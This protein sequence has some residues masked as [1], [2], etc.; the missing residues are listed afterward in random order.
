MN[1]VPSLMDLQKYA[2]NRPGQQEVIRQPLYDTAVYAT[3]GSTGISFFATPI[4]QGASASPGN[5]GNVKTIADTNMTLAGQ[6]PAGQNFMVEQIEV[7]VTPGASAATTTTFT[8][9]HPVVF[10]VAASA[11]TVFAAASDVNAIYQTG[12]LTLTIGSKNYLQDGPLKKFAPQNY[13]DVESSVESTS[14][15]VGQTLV[16]TAR[17]L[18]K[19]YNIVPVTLVSTQNFNVTLNWPV[20]VATPSGFNA[21]VRCTLNGYLFRNSQ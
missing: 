8:L 15:T 18:G 14:A 21:A 16:S 5:A 13:V 2:V 9:V 1:N 17:A 6:L 11:G 7:D 3:A 19:P 10:A 12:V 20:V 4:G